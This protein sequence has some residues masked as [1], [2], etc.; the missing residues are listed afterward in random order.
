DG[1]QP[2]HARCLSWQIPDAVGG[3]EATVSIWTT[4]GRLKGVP[5]LAAPHDLV[6][7]RTRSIGETDLICRDGKWFLYATVEAPQAPLTQPVNGFLGVDLGIVNAAINIARRG[8]ESWGE[9]MHPY[10]APTLT[11]S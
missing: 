7:L 5:V 11:A 8:V 4:A 10:A 6:R 3:R 9:V 1:A 2:F